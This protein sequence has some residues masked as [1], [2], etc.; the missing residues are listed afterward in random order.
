MDASDQPQQ[1]QHDGVP[2]EVVAVVRDASPEATESM[3]GW[4][5]ASGAAAGRVAARWDTWRGVHFTPPD[6]EPPWTSREYDRVVAILERHPNV[7]RTDTSPAA[8]SAG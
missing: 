6:D 1:W 2:Q 8:G 5:I 7:L 3:L 4:L